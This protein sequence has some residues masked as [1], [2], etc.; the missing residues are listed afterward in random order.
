MQSYYTLIALDL[1]R[2]ILETRPAKFRVGEL[3]PLN[4]RTHRAV[5]HEDAFGRRL[6]QSLF[7]VHHAA[8]CFGV[9]RKPSRW[10]IA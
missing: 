6:A 2:V 1:A 5:E 10:Q 9:G 4:H 7:G 8:S 3:Q